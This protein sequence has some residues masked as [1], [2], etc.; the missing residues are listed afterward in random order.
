MECDAYGRCVSRCKQLIYLYD[1]HIVGYAVS[2]RIYI[3]RKPF[4]TGESYQSFH[5]CWRDFVVDLCENRIQI[6]MVS[7]VDGQLF[8]GKRVEAIPFDDDATPDDSYID[9]DEQPNGEVKTQ[10]PFCP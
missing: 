8:F 6:E 1:I 10:S 4:G 5:A 3:R 9:E 2:A 7:H